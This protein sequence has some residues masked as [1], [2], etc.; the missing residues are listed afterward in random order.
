MKTVSKIGIAALL[1]GAVVAPL[2]LAQDQKPEAPAAAEAMPGTGEGGM[3]GMM[4]EGM[5]SEEGM[6]M[7]RMMQKMEPMM[8]ACMAMMKKAGE[9]ET[10][11]SSQGG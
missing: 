6:P 11:P 7:M 3:Q 10:A 4:G 2:A 1:A 8:D 5:M 9:A